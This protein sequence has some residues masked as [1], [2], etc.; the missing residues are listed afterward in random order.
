MLSAL[1]LPGGIPKYMKIPTCFQD[2]Q[3]SEKVSPRPPTDSK[4]TPKTFPPDNKLL[5]KSKTWNHS[6]H[7]VFTMVMA[8]PASQGRS[9]FLLKSLRKRLPNSNVDFH[10]QNHK[11]V[12]NLSR[13]WLPRGSQNTP[14]ISKIQLWS[15]KV[16][17]EVSL[18]PLDDQKA[19]PGHQKG[20]SKSPT[21][22]LRV[23]K[24]HPNS[25]S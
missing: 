8:H 17:Q 12:S 25:N 3:K 14:Q 9:Y 15:P 11:I 20:A 7:M 23:S 22:H 5:N 19:H 1:G 18:W 21:R 13:K 10:I 24:S 16:S 2:P 6:K 4:M